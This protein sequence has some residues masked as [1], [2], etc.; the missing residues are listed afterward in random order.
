MTTIARLMTTTALRQLPVR[1]AFSI[2]E[3]SAQTGI[4]RDTV[5]GA[6]RSGQLVA[7]KIGRRT[8]ITQKDLARFLARLPRTGAA[9]ASGKDFSAA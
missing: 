9:Q 1:A 6:I 4:S 7:R 8:L 2:A 3:V 5:Y